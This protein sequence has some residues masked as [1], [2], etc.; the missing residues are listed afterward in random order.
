MVHLDA[1]QLHGLSG[2][3][4]QRTQFRRIVV[5]GIDEGTA[6]VRTVDEARGLLQGLSGQVAQ[7]Q[8]A[9]MASFGDWSL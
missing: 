1:V 6:A 5:E 4:W 9:D 8:G 3:R 2:R 7:D